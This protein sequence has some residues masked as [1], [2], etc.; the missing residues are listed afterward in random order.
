M[1]CAIQILSLTA[2]QL[3]KL[4]QHS[5]A[6]YRY[7]TVDPDVIKEILPLQGQIVWVLYECY[8]PDSDTEGVQEELFGH[9]CTQHSN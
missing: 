8:R 1:V 7:T 6:A 2:I 9:F 4:A 3:S 5:A